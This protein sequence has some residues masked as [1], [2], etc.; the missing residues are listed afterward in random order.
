M[1]TIKRGDMVRLKYSKSEVIDIV[2]SVAIVDT[3]DGPVFK[4]YG[5]E[6]WTIAGIN[7]ELVE[8]VIFQ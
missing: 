2:K 8:K 7:L 4:V 6:C 3:E 5:T 1:N